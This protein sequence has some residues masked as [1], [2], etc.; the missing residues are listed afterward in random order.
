MRRIIMILATAVLA[1]GL[2][3]AVAA[4]E[5]AL[6]H[7]GRVLIVAGGDVE[8]A[9]DEQAD[10][11]LVFGGDARIAGTVNTLL[12]IDGTATVDGA[13]IETIAVAEGTADL[14][15]E[16]TVLG[17]VLEFRATVDRAESVAIGGTVRDMAGDIAAFGIFMG[18]AALAIWVG[19]GIATLLA[20]LLV[21]G[22]AA[23]QVHAATTLISR[24]PG[25]TAL[26]G[27]LAIVVP[28][29]LAALAMVTV[30]GIPAGLGLLLVVWP[31][32]AFIGY[33]VAA[34]WIGEY[35]L[36]RR[37]D[38]AADRPYAASTVGLVIAFVIGLVPVVTAIVSIFGLGAVVL[39]GY[40]TLRGGG[41]RREILNAQPAPAA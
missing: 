16:T 12:V 3:G 34:I 10:A 32:V 28:P 40:R 29:I 35:V 38:D 33:I 24:E 37:G 30:I 22:L 27:L 17:D 4:A 23:R 8:V 6:P 20:G 14:I 19:F 1:L 36:G 21:A 2:T 9:A 11:V 31:A 25:R 41:A 26:V 5:D 13:T 7:S 15:G 18:I 39:A